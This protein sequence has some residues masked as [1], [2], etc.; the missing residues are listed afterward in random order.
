MNHAARDYLVAQLRA[1]GLAP[2]VQRAVVQKNYVDYNANY[3]A[4]M[5]VVHNVL[6]RLPGARPTGCGAR[7]LLL[8]AQIDSETASLG[9]ARSA[10]PMAAL[11]ET[12]R[13]LRAGTPPA[14]DIRCC[15]PMASVSAAWACRPSPSSIR[16]RAK[17]A[18]HCVST[19]WGAAAHWN[20]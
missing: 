6:V 20:W 7:P 19:A 2:H 15:S 17:S 1:L 9:A 4:T 13:A 5:G 10:A 16:G 8:V 12:V 14:N 3:E 11:L 18:W